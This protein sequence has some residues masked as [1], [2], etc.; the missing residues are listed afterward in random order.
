MLLLKLRCQVSSEG[1]G[2]H[3]TEVIGLRTPNR[4]DFGGWGGGVRRAR[5]FARPQKTLAAA[6]E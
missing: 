6:L 2:M 4:G 1:T 3:V 5:F